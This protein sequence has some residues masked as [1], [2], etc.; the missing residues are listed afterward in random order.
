MTQIT[1]SPARSETRRWVTAFVLIIILAAFLTAALWDIG[2]TCFPDSNCIAQG[3]DIRLD[4]GTE[5]HV[6]SLHLLI[7]E[8]KPAEVK[9]YS[10]SDGDW[11]LEGTLTES[12]TYRQWLDYKFDCSTRYIRLVFKKAEGEIGEVALFDDTR[13]LEIR[14]ITDADGQEICPEL[15]D[16][17]S[18]VTSPPTY[19]NGTYFDE[20][21]FVRTA[22]EHLNLEEAFEWSHPP[23]G[24][25]IISLGIVLFGSNPFAWRITGVLAAAVMIVIAYLLG[26]RMMDNEWAGLLTAFLL[27]FDFMHLTEARLAT[28]ES[29]LA[30]FLLLMFYFFHRYYQ[31]PDYR[32]RDL[33]LSLLCFGLAFTVKWVAIFGLVAIVV[34][35]MFTKKHQGITR[36]ET[37]GLLGGILAAAA[38]Y[39]LA[40]I[41]YFLQGH[42]LTGLFELQ[43]SMFGYHSGLESTHPYSSSWWSWPFV[44]CPMWLYTGQIGDWSSNILL[45]G[46]PILWLGSLPCL[47]FTGWQAIRRHDRTAMFISIAFAAQWILFAAIPRIVFIYHYYPNVVFLALATTFCLLKLEPRRRWIIYT[48]LALVLA[49]FCLVY[50]LISGLPLSPENWMNQLF[51]WIRGW[52][53]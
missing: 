10:G 17:Q 42:S 8:D 39:F 34:L 27:A 37:A 32:G 46:N 49:A 19:A 18:M 16:E 3:K 31:G 6:T 11:T 1:L 23:L 35:F 21:Y 29:F 2:A 26:R 48:Y 15:V 52:Q 22:E 38:V 20:I 44:C 50:P 33:F 51:Q 30:L 43:F 47:F 13:Q 4:L 45:L 24:K 7:Q 36:G 12:G 28:G 14:Q 40:Y 53:I 9:I 25:L 5:S 41:P